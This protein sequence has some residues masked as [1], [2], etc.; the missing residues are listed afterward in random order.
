MTIGLPGYKDVSPIGRG[1]FS[2]VFRAR[3]V[4]FDRWVAIKVLDVGLDRR[5][6]EAFERECRAMGVVSQH[7]NIVTVLSAAFTDDGR[8]AIV[9][10]LFGGGTFADRLKRDGPLPGPDALS[11][12]IR[13]S[14][15]LQSAHDRG[16][17]HRDVKPQNLFVSEYGEPALGDF[18]ISSFADEE[19]GSGG[20]L[21]VHYAA[22]EV[23]EHQ[24]AS[25]ASDVYA[26]AATMYTLVAG[27]RPFSVP[28]QRQRVSDVALRILKEPPPRIGDP[29]P[30][31]L[32]RAILQGLA[33][34]PEERPA[35]A[36]SFG[37]LLQAAQEGIG[38]GRTEL[39][40]ARQTVDDDLTVA[41]EHATGVDLPDDDESATMARVSAPPAEVDQAR[42]P[43][44][45]RGGR[46]STPAA[47]D[48][49]GAP[50]EAPRRRAALSAVIGVVAVAVVAGIGIWAAGDRGDEDTGTPLA[51]GGTS[52]DPS[53]AEDD[54]FVRVDPPDD[55]EVRRDGD[56]AVTVTWTADES[57]SYEVQRVDDGANQR[58]MTA[59]G[60]VVLDDVDDGDRPCVV[61][62]ALSEAGQLS[63]ASPPACTRG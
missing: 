43:R 21:T 7:P 20:G 26:L 63:A 46:D 55:I 3:Q 25:P 45:Q 24:Q 53:V 47:D 13:I 16:L 54:F 36:A 14:G 32:E 8:P 38:M 5:Q 61:V 37:R 27:R 28:G 23:I 22:P 10:E 50:V 33:K 1:G 42:S 34:R 11:V 2:Q 49:D 48:H 17:L 31:P 15:A 51:E 19:A 41:R 52:P 57:L 18:G 6:R 59:G 62:R 30:P 44:G 60:S 40:V 58:I 4:G 39:A 29:C 9:M 12:G 35:S 56:G